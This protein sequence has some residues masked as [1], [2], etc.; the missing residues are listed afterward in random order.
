M[1]AAAP[2]DGPL[3]A[4]VLIVDDD[5][6]NLLAAVR[7]ASAQWNPDLI[8]SNEGGS[9]IVLV[10]S[11]ARIVEVQRIVLARELLRSVR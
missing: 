2:D 1:T 3:R 5:E 6:R 9:N 10:R 11:P 8:A 7:A 4:R